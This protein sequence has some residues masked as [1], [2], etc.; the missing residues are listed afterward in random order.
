MRDSTSM[1]N[2]AGEHVAII[3]FNEIVWRLAIVV[4]ERE[5]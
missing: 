2:R 1:V 3:G 5:N 4:V